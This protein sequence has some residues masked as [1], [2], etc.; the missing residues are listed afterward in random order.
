MLILPFDAERFRTIPRWL[1]RLRL[2]VLLGL[3]AAGLA[4][5]AIRS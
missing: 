5:L 2:L 1:L 3:L 4:F